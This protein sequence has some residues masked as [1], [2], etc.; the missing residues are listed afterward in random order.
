MS[1]KNAQVLKAKSSRFRISSF[2]ERSSG[3]ELIR[4]RGSYVVG[5]A[6]DDFL[7]AYAAC[8]F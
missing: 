1:T 4:K 7:E 8:V 6:E 2:P 3:K 5:A